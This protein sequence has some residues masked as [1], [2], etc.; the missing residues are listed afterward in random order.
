MSYSGTDT[1]LEYDA[2]RWAEF[3]DDID[4]YDDWA[5]PDCSSRDSIADISLKMA[6]L[7]VFVFVCATVLCALAGAVIHKIHN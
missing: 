3:C 1:D 4:D 2:R 6:G 7:L 5:Q